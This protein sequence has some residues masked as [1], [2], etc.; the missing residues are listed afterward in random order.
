MSR[1]KKKAWTEFIACSICILITIAGTLLMAHTNAKGLEFLLIWVIVGVPTGFFI[2]VW[3]QKR[4]KQFDEREREM[5]Q[6]AFSASMLAFV[7]Y[8][9]TLSLASFFLIGGGGLVPVVFLP[10]MF[11]SGL[12]FAQTIQSFI[13]LMQCAKEDDE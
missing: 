2:Y 12:F 8:L 13:L 9:L 4:L 11:F 10:L 3:E 6:K 5:I 7:L 1:L